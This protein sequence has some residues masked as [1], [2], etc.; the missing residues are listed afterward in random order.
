M[1]YAGVWLAL[2]PAGWCALALCIQTASLF[3]PGNGAIVGD[4]GIGA[5][6]AGG[7]GIGEIIIAALPGVLLWLAGWIVEGF[8]KDRD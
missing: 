6:V 7:F 2:I 4:L 8:A 3:H 1:R 5:I